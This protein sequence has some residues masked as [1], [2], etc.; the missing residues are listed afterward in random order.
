[1]IAA[2]MNPQTDRRHTAAPAAVPVRR[3]TWQRDA[4]RAALANRDTFVSAQQ[5]HRELADQGVRIGL[6]TVY[7]TLAT[8]TDLGEADTVYGD[9]GEV[10]YRG[11]GGD[12]HHHHLLCRECGKAIEI[13]GDVVEAWTKEVARRYGF[14][15]VVHT[16]NLVGVC[17]E[18]AAARRGD[19]EELP[20]A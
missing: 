3:H 12:D 9:D 7:R 15:D 5:L 2:I 10:L 4:V 20:R 17:P 14:E 11:C 6:A 8:L 13:R 16:L 19:A 1:M 18:C